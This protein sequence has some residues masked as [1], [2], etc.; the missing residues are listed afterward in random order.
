MPNLA[1]AESAYQRLLAHSREVHLLESTSEVLGWDQEVMM[2]AGGVDH[3]A[4][5]LALLARLAH[6]RA[7]A[8]ELDDLLAAA[9]E[10]AAARGG[11]G[12]GSSLQK[13]AG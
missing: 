12:T 7:T 10:E 6:E 13:T 2:P 3:R 4:R 8:P 11:T 9:D 1:H 5:Q